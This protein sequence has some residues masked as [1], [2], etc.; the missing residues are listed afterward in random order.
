MQNVFIG[1]PKLN[2]EYTDAYRARFHAERAKLG[3]MQ[4]SP[5]YRRTTNVIRV[6]INTADMVDG[7]EVTSISFQNLATSN[8]WGT[9]LNGSAAA[10]VASSTAS[11]ASTCSRW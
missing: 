1:N 2:P 6:D 3:T 10:R 11:P 5:F 8:S 7:R 4:L 9:D